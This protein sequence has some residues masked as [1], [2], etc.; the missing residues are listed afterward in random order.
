MSFFNW[1]KEFDAGERK[2]IA[3][4]LLSI[5]VIITIL[6]VDVIWSKK[7]RVNESQLKILSQTDE[8]LEKLNQEKPSTKETRVS[9]VIKKEGPSKRKKDQL[10]FFNPDTLTTEH[11]ERLGFSTKQSK[12][13]IKYRNALGGS[14]TEETFK[15]SFVVDSSTFLKLQPYISFS[16]KPD[17]VI[18]EKEDLDRLPEEASVIDVQTADASRLKHL[19]GIGP[20]LSKRIVAYRDQLGG[21]Y[22]INQLLDV[23]GVDQDWLEEN[24]NSLTIGDRKCKKI[25]INNAS[26]DELK[27]HPYIDYSLAKSIINYIKYRGAF[28]NI[29]DLMKIPDV[30]ESKVIKLEPY[31]NFSND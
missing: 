10:F 18:F 23:Y 19:K 12:A 31:I 3:L 14:F 30:E 8:E 21:F 17:D 4:L 16:S 27:R 1:F 29:D 25:S 7:V 9:K 22:K 2:T 6:N 5:V 24:K 26:F 28:K 20:V 11:W 15:A 13:L